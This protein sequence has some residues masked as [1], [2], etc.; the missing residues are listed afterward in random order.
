MNM[1]QAR[2]L[3]TSHIRELAIDLQTA[4]EVPLCLRLLDAPLIDDPILHIDDALA[5][6]K[7]EVRELETPTVGKLEVHNLSDVRI[8]IAPFTL[9]QGG[10]QNRTV[11]EPAVVAPGTSVVVEVHCV[12]MG[13]WNPRSRGSFRRSGSAPMAFKRRSMKAYEAGA[14][15]TRAE[16][17]SQTATWDRVAVSLAACGARSR[18]SDLMEEVERYRPL[19]VPD[20]D[21]AAGLLS[22]VDAVGWTLESSS[23][24]SLARAVRRALAASLG[25]LRESSSPP[26][27]V[28]LD[29]RFDHT[30]RAVLEHGKWDIRPILGGYHAVLTEDPRLEHVFGQAVLDETGVLWLSLN[31]APELAEEEREH[32]RRRRHAPAAPGARERIIEAVT[33]LRSLLSAVVREAY[34]ATDHVNDVLRRFEAAADRSPDREADRDDRIRRI[35]RSLIRH[36]A[37]ELARRKMRSRSDAE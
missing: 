34:P 16:R 27:D 35:P 20:R 10:G 18:T 19:E 36:H 14:R 23:R 2:H 31:A 13:R 28:G 4:V 25:S 33:E 32:P 22:Q 8:L 24:P 5:E 37:L 11:I 12:Q 15:R 26:A 29:V 9:L 17:F 21:G 7:A 30:R 6:G 3:L 1:I